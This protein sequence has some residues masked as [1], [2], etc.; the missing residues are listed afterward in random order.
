MPKEGQ[1]IQIGLKLV[2]FIDT[3]KA[4]QPHILLEPLVKHNPRQRLPLVLLPNIRRQA[5]L[6][7]EDSVPVSLKT[8]LISLIVAQVF[9]AAN[10]TIFGRPSTG[11]F[12]GYY[13][14]RN[15]SQNILPTAP[16]ATA[17]LAGDWTLWYHHDRNHWYGPVWSMTAASTKDGT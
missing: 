13:H 8:W 9:S 2:L 6:T 15:R 3:S 4:P 11:A 7:L 17:S 1:V 14:C 5:H 16:A 12:G 10:K